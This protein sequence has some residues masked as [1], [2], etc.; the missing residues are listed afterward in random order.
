MIFRLASAIPLAFWLVACSEAGSTTGIAI[1][2]DRI[3]QP[4]SAQPGRADIGERVFA[5]RN[6]GHCVLCHSVVG[7]D[8]PFQ[9]NIG[10]DLS[11]VG[12]R[13]T[14]A[15]LRLRVVDYQALKPDTLMPSYYRTEGLHQVE[16]GQ[17]GQTILTAQQVEDLVAYLTSLRG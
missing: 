1:T 8:V 2:D 10:P 5:E 14:P 17:I 9:G 7:L 6:F 16:I 4:L 11:T 15:Q 3:E 12:L 13:L